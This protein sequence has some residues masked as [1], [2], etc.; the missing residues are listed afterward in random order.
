MYITSCLFTRHA[1]LRKKNNK[2]KQQKTHLSPFVFCFCV[3]GC[4]WVC[5]CLLSQ[6]QR[7]VWWLRLDLKVRVWFSS[8]S[9]GVRHLFANTRLRVNAKEMHYIKECPHNS[10]K[11]CVFFC[12]PSSIIFMFNVNVNLIYIAHLKQLGWPMCFTG[13]MEQQKDS[14]T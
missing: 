10:R 13:V 5:V 7:V 9:V 3:C 4:A 1:V 11:V 2:G 12:S 8:V 14:K 6:L